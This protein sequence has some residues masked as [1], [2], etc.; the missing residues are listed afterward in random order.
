MVKLCSSEYMTFINTAVREPE[1]CFF[2][3]VQR[4]GWGG[5]N[6]KGSWE[7]KLKAL[8]VT[9]MDEMGEKSFNTYSIR[10]AILGKKH[11]K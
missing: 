4:F 5:L 3:Q 7:W 2:C 8:E 6:F 11:L 10:N 1:N 9:I